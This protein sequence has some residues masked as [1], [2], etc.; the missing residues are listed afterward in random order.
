[1]EGVCDRRITV[2]CGVSSTELQSSLLGIDIQVITH[3]NIRY[4]MCPLW[5]NELIIFIFQRSTDE[6]LL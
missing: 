1:M 3:L 6:N 2:G 5:D 4:E